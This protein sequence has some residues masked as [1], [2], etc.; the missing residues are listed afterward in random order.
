[1]LYLV[2]QISVVLKQHALQATCTT[3]K[4]PV[5]LFISEDLPSSRLTVYPA[6]ASAL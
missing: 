6:L 4:V 3:E 2:K 5:L 1:M